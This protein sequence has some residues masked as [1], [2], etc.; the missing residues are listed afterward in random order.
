[1]TGVFL[2]QNNIIISSFNLYDD[3]ISDQSYHQTALEKFD[4]I[5]TVKYFTLLVSLQGLECPD[6]DL[7]ADA[8]PGV[9]V[10]LLHDL[11][12]GHDGAGLARAR[13]PLVD[14][15]A[16]LLR[17][18]PV[19]QPP[20]LGLVAPLEVAP[21]GQVLQHLLDALHWQSSVNLSVVEQFQILGG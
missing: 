7:L 20:P 8:A 18:A 15:L 12:G 19:H 11:G 1:M 9:G 10:A 3:M 2:Y 14:V 21:G 5:I 4:P 13:H 6:D 17:A 16:E